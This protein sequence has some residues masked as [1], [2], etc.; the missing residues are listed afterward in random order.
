M[1]NS[2]QLDAVASFWLCGAK[3]TDGAL[4]PQWG[5]CRG[6]PMVNHH[7]TMGHLWYQLEQQRLLTPGPIPWCLAQ[8]HC[9]VL[10]WTKHTNLLG[11]R[12]E[13]GWGTCKAYMMGW[14]QHRKHIR[15]NTPKVL[16]RELR[17]PHGRSYQQ[18]TCVKSRPQRW[19]LGILMSLSYFQHCRWNQIKSGKRIRAT[20]LGLPGW[21]AIVSWWCWAKKNSAWNV[22]CVSWL[23]P[24]RPV[25]GCGVATMPWRRWRCDS[26]WGLSWVIQKWDIL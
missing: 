19:E 15:L 21:G 25:L 9:R 2:R 10:L 7:G 11:V 3:Q 16:S 22:C 13:S 14:T 1:P 18:N 23:P 4:D 26:G 8:C 5:I 20:R 24:K 6:E 12:W 17:F